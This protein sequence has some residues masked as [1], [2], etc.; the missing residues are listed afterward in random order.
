MAAD[1][2]LFPRVPTTRVFVVMEGRYTGLYKPSGN[3]I[4]AQVRHVLRFWGG[5]LVSFQQYLDTGQLQKVM[6]LR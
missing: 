4:D 5:K 3:S 6:A 2:H 1:P